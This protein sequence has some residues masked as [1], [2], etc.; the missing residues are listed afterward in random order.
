MPRSRITYCKVNTNWHTDVRCMA[1]G[2]AVGKWLL[3]VLWLEACK[4]RRV[5]LG[6]EYSTSSIQRLCG[7]DTRSVHKYLAKLSSLKLIHICADGRIIVYGVKGCNKSLDWKDGYEMYPEC[8]E[9]GQLGVISISNKEISNKQTNNDGGAFFKG[10]S[11]P[12]IDAVNLD[13]ITSPIAR[14]VIAYKKK[15]AN[16]NGDKVRKYF[17]GEIKN[18]RTESEIL[19][20]INDAPH[21]TPVWKL[22][23][24]KP[25]KK[26]LTPWGALGI[27]EDEYRQSMEGDR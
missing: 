25:I 18:G 27:S 5:R 17:E 9:Q 20:A 1:I 16:M 26:R 23:E 14:C 7:F 6:Y 8:T 24:G 15:G 13:D 3:H 10:E 22:F 12:D 21:N 19:Q 4:C 2:S 11:E